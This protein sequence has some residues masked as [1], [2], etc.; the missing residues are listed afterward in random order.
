[1]KNLRLLFAFFVL[2]L[3]LTSCKSEKELIPEDCTGVHWSHHESEEGQDKWPELCSGYSAC[4]GQS[5]SPV[6]IAGSVTD[7]SL[8][9]L[10]F[11]YATTHK[12]VRICNPY[13][14]SQI[15]HHSLHLKKHEFIEEI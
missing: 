10:V 12:L 9:D 3:A 5:Q 2:S 7:T 4:G 15:A 6:N 11:S 1:M 8:S 13:P 14:D